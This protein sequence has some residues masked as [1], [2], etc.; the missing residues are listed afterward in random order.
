[1]TDAVV[2]VLEVVHVEEQHADS[3]AGLRGALQA[4]VEQIEELSAVG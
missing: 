4:G 2:D 1:V 3:A